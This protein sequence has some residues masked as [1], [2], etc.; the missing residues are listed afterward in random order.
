MGEPLVLAEVVS[1]R[2]HRIRLTLRQCSTSVRTTITWPATG[3]WCWRP[4]PILMNS[5]EVR[6]VSLLPCGPTLRPT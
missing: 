4:S 2:G 5:W 3:P 6:Q 1:V